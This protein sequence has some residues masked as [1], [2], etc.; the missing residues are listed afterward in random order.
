MLRRFDPY[1]TRQVRA[2]WWRWVSENRLVLA[3]LALASLVAVV[4]MTVMVV[5]TGHTGPVRF[6]VLGVAHTALVGGL[7]HSVRVL[8]LAHR[9]E[10]IKHVRGA[11]GESNTRSEL[12]SA[13]R[14][15]II[16]GRIDSIDLVAGDIDHLAI[17][18]RAGVLAIDS[19]WRSHIDEHDRQQMA[20]SARRC[21][22]RVTGLI[23][24][25]AKR[26]DAPPALVAIARVPVR[27]VVVIWGGAQADMPEHTYADGV[28]FVRGKHL[29]R[30][31]RGQEG[32]TVP[33]ASARALSTALA[34]Y[35]ARQTQHAR[36]AAVGAR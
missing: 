31:L 34:A 7:L 36:V 17:T 5:G 23:N 35:R 4:I 21:Q 16:W 30:W 9:G 11:T 6:Y 1:S 27:P 32:S 25:V 2:L 33:R 8:F 13:R 19:K 18:R 26:R 10:A 29:T 14:R 28:D 12:A 24:T 3:M 20:Q 22:T 15:R